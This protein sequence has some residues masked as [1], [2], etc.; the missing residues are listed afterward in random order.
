MLFKVI[1]TMHIS[2]ISNIKSSAISRIS[3]RISSKSSSRVSLSPLKI[4]RKNS[5]MSLAI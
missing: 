1:K 2:N 5:R 4:D 3:S